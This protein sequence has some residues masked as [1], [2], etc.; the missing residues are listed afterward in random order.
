VNSSSYFT[1]IKKAELLI[2][3]KNFKQASKTY[4]KAFNQ[5]KKPFGKDLFNA[6]L[7][8]QL[9]NNLKERDNRLQSVIDNS[10]ELDYVKSKF[11]GIYLTE[12][13]WHE[14]I[15]KQKIKYNPT[16]RNEFNEIYE[17]DQNFRPMYETHDD[18]INANR[19]INMERILSLTDSIGFPSQIELG[20]TN[21]LRGQKHDIVL[22]HT[23]QRRSRDK[24]VTDLEPILFEAV[25]QGRFDPDQAIFYLNFQNDLEKGIFEVYSTWQ[26]KHPLLPDSL[27]NKIWLTKLD[28]KQKLM[29]NIKRKEW[30][31]NSLEEIAVKSIFLTKNNLPFIFTCVHKSIGNLSEDFDKETALEQY[32][33]ATSHMEEY[34]EKIVTNKGLKR[35]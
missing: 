21:Y 1:L 10:N 8:S 24:T 32:K 19:K 25:Q 11:V 23:A 35:S 9:S 26:Y 22:H 27:N 15:S 28:E 20:F 3:E 14:L 17:R 5:I 31:A 16:L 13:H 18:T 33:R 34:K 4:T 2:C 29:A 6:A 30:Y 12:K 7:A